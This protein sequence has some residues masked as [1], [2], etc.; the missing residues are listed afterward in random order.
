MN[1][2]FT[3]WVARGAATFIALGLAGCGGQ[4]GS[5]VDAVPT[6]TPDQ[7]ATAAAEITNADRRAT[8]DAPAQATTDAIP[9]KD[10]VAQLRRE[11]ADLRRIVARSPSATSVAA[12]ST[13]P[14]TDP[15][16]RVEA[17]RAAQQRLASAEAAFRR[18][19]TD[20]RADQ[21]RADNLRASLLEASEA[22]GKHLGSVDC[23]GQSC[24]VELNA[25]PHSRAMQELPMAL[26]RLGAGF[27]H[28]TAGQI[29][30]GDGR[31][32]M[33]MFLTR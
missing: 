26:L 17:E 2:D 14:R 13:D 12:E 10:E 31:K 4:A 29:D 9:L 3:P 32:S 27:P 28:M 33:V 21:G 7:P 5:R 25:A 19:T 20:Y 30:H 16:A 23:R 11:L 24:R 22:I 18:Q 1:P 15:N 6:A 8:I